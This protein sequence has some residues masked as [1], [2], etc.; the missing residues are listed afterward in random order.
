MPV[1]LLLAYDG[2]DFLGYQ[3]QPDRHEPTVQSVLEK[4]LDHLDGGPVKTSVAGRT[5]AGVHAQGNVVS[6]N[7]RRQERF[8][9][10]EWRN[11][12]NA[13]TSKNLAVRAALTVADGVDARRSATE[14]AYRYRVLCDPIRD[15][16]RERY[17]HRVRSQVTIAAMQDACQNLVGI[18][19]FGAFGH[20]PSNQTGKPRRTTMRDLRKAAITQ[21]DDEIWFDFAANAF[22]TGMVRRMVGTLLMVGLGFMT[23]ADFAAILAARQ[24]IHPGPAAPAQGLC[25]MRVAY[26]PGTIQWPADNMMENG[27]S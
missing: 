12:V 3:R 8:G 10:D 2:T 16:L 13:L 4:A 18:H 26:P 5:D 9:P 14:R 27:R 19:D 20:S 15:P 11:A 21:H 1:A 22:L 17:T 24:I 6:F 25:L 7:P 23:P